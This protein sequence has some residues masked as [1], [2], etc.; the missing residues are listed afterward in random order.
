MV[1]SE[2]QRNKEG[3]I[4][5]IDTARIIGLLAMHGIT[6]EKAAERLGIARVT[7]TRKLKNETI[8]AKELN[9]LSEMM[10]EPIE[11]FFTPRGS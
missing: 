3:G 11:K 4:K 9:L 1:S 2:I 10:N 8:T 5:L 6:R 7:F